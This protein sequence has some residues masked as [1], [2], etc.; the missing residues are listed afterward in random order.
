MKK[1]RVFVTGT[2]GTMGGETMKQL[3]NRSDRFQV[4]TLARDSEKNRTFM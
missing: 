3:L 2:T 4:V 1:K